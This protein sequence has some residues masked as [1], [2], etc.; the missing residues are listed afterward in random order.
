MDRTKL[1]LIDIA[2]AGASLILDGG[3]FD[4]LELIDIAK[5]ILKGSTLQ[6]TNCQT[7][8]KYELIDIAQAAPGKVIFS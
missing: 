1:E 8:T 5:A 7:K 6:I 3:K 2:K 4:K